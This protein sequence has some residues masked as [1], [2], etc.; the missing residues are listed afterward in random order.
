MQKSQKEI[1]VDNLEAQLTKLKQHVAR[2][3][4]NAHDAVEVKEGYILEVENLENEIS[5]KQ[6]ELSQILSDIKRAESRAQSVNENISEAR[7]D[8]ENILK[9][10]E[11]II[12]TF[13]KEVSGLESD[14][15]VGKKEVK[16]IEKQIAFEQ[17][18]FEE[19]KPVFQKEIDRLN[20]QIEL[21]RSAISE[22]DDSIADRAMLLDTILNETIAAQKEAEKTRIKLK[23]RETELEKIAESN[24]K[25]KS[26]LDTRKKDIDV[27][28]RRIKKKYEEEFPGRKIKL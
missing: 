15:E 26:E 1:Q 3:V 4:K 23:A 2:A 20:K 11:E 14:V 5:E 21:R 25:L 19:N 27:I 9:S 22:Y 10:R 16:R 17:N 6:L 13:K 12:S 7:A 28:S 24:N 8:L 18:R